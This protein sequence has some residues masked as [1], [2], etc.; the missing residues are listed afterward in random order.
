MLKGAGHKLPGLPALA[1]KARLSQTLQGV[2]VVWS[3][4]K[5]ACQLPRLADAGQLVITM[6]PPFCMGDRPANPA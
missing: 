6:D 4:S 1:I 2:V 3:Y 5:A